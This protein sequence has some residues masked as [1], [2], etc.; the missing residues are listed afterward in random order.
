MKKDNLVTAS[1]VEYDASAKEI[2]EARDAVIAD[3]ISSTVSDVLAYRVLW[4]TEAEKAEVM[5]LIARLGM[6]HVDLL[7]A[8]S[9]TDNITVLY[10]KINYL[11]VA[12]GAMED[13]KDG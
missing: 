11:A 6:N 5:R 13:G 3:V 10:G 4:R 9:S 8:G 2:I 7:E 12:L 1:G